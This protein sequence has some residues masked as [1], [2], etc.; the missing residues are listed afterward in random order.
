MKHTILVFLCFYRTR[1]DN[2]RHTDHLRGLNQSLFAETIVEH[3]S[4]RI[5]CSETTQH[6]LSKLPAYTHLSS[7]YSIVN[8][9]QPTTIQHPDDQRTNNIA[10]ILPMQSII[11]III[12]IGQ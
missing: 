3:R 4:I 11:R 10:M 7:I 1:N 5:Y 8:I 6:F 2:C 12:Q 9:N